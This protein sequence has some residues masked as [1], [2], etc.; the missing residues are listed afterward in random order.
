MFWRGP[1]CVFSCPVLYFSIEVKS[2]SGQRIAYWS[3]IIAQASRDVKTAFPGFFFLYR[4]FFDFCSYSA[5]IIL[6]RIPLTRHQGSGIRHQTPPVWCSY[7]ITGYPVRN[8]YVEIPAIYIKETVK[9]CKKQRYLH[10][11]Q[12]LER[13]TS[14]QF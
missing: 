9:E 10:A 12:T 6:L 4:L 1:S 3:Y 2:A 5:A 8:E 14:V 7:N 11:L 13:G